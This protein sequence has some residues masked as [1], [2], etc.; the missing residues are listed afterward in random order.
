MKDRKLSAKKIEIIKKSQVKL[1]EQINKTPEIFNN[2]IFTEWPQQNQKVEQQK[3][4]NLR[5]RGKNKT[6]K[7]IE[8]E[9]LVEQYEKVIG[10]PRREE[11]EYFKK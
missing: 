1:L 6:N 4:S 5:N 9:G 10:V 2:N 11:K 3:F 7:R 8:Y